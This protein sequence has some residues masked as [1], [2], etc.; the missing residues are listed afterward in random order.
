MS[1][2]ATLWTAAHQAPHPWDPQGKN[3]GVECHDLLQG[4]FPTQGSNAGLLCLLHWEADSL[5]LVSP[6]KEISIIE[7]IPI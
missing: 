4:I 3:P 6:G 5:P 2:S 1:D 7:Y